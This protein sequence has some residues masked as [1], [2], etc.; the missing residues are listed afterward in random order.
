MVSADSSVLR[1]I[2]IQKPY[3]DMSGWLT[4]ICTCCSQIGNPVK[5]FIG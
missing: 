1:A 3:M 4:G 5:Y 2:Q